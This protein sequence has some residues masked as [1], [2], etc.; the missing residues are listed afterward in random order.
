MAEY[1][2][3]DAQEVSSSGSILFTTDAVPCRKGYIYHRP[4]SGVFT[5]R[6]VTTSCFARYL[7]Q[8]GGNIAVPEGGTAGAISVAIAIDGEIIPTSK[9]VV[10]PAA[11]SQYFNVS[12]FSYITVPK[13]CCLNVSI[14][15]SSGSSIMVENSNLLINRVA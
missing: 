13:G 8:F 9:A 5:L 15:N 12:S 3:N 14:E 7:V 11:V 4:G 1:T 10:T 6:G 2:T